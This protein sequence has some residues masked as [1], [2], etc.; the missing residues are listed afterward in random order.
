MATQHR[1]SRKQFRTPLLVPAVGTAGGCPPRRRARCP[2]APPADGSARRGGFL[3]TG[4]APPPPVAGGLFRRRLAWCPTPTPP[5]GT[6]RRGHLAGLGL[7]ARPVPP[8]RRDARSPALDVTAHRGTA[9]RTP[10][11][12]TGSAP[13]AVSIPLRFHLG[14]GRHTR[15]TLP[16]ARAV[17]FPYT[18]SRIMA[19]AS[20]LTFFRGEDVVLDFQMSPMEDVSGWAISLKIGDTLGGTVQVT[21]TASITDGPRGKFR[22]TIASADTASLAAG[23]YTW[24]C[25]R[26]DSGAKATLANGELDLKREVTA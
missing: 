2:Q 24:D 19:V 22:V 6:T 26:T 16:A 17:P 1:R 15:L 18:A 12:H 14:A 9:N 21:K 23:R 8:P 25:R 10:L 3:H 5:P 13:T 4:D 20:N 11:L 7:T